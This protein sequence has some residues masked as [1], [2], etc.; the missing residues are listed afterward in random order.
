M[1]IF[2][3]MHMYK[4]ICTYIYVYIYI[5]RKGV[6]CHWKPFWSLINHRPST[7]GEYLPYTDLKSLIPADPTHFQ[8]W[9]AILVMEIAGL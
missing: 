7:F 9:L 3:Y 1:Y 6:G 8:K 5:Y 4:Y 2:I